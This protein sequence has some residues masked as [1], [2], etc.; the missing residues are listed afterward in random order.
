MVDI[1]MVAYPSVTLLVDLS[2]GEGVIYETHGR[3]ERG[4][5]VLGLLS[6]DLRA[7]G[8]GAGQRLQ[9]RLEPVAA[10]ALF[11]ASTELQDG[12]T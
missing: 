1:A 3:H 2:E 9:I 7:A 4:S 10:A 12:L 8:R 11:G 6:G 5:V